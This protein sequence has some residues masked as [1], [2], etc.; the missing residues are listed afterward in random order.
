MP[1]FDYQQLMENDYTLYQWLVEL[2]FKTGIAKI[3]N[4]PVEKLQLQKLGNRVGYLVSTN[5]G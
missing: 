1:V 2:A 3:E 5:Y 4:I